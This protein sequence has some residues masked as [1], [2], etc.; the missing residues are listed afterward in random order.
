MPLTLAGRIGGPS[1]EYVCHHVVANLVG[2]ELDADA[3]AVVPLLGRQWYVSR[4][5]R[6]HH[7]HVV[8][9]NRRRLYGWGSD[10]RI[11]GIH[12]EG[13]VSQWESAAGGSRGEWVAPVIHTLAELG[14]NLCCA[15]LGG[16]RW[17]PS[18]LP[19]RRCRHCGANACVSHHR[20]QRE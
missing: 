2:V 19:P 9:R 16:G 8:C 6:P 5:P 3:H 7:H 4:R 13:N 1:R 10:N 15:A 17:L 11:V 14:G 20:R 12:L 18:E